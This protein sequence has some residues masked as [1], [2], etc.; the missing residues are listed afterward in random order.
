MAG[1]AVGLGMVGRLQLPVVRQPRLMLRE[2]P[3]YD[4]QRRS[5]VAVRRS[6]LTVDVSPEPASYPDLEGVVLSARVTPDQVR[7]VV[8]VSGVG[9]VDA[10]ASVNTHPAPGERVRLGVDRSR[11]A[12]IR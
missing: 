9:E 3:T 5:A 8:D 10:V 7:L 1:Q 4:V 2:V 11:L 6:A 12:V